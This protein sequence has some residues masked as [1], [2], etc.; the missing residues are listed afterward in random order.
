M[1]M[2]RR[3]F[4]KAVGVVGAGTVAVTHVPAVTGAATALLLKQK[5]EPLPPVQ[6]NDV[7][8]ASTW[9]ALVDRVNELSEAS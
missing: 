7:M 3:A 8:T 5:P 9:N 2:N 6:A 4:L 1:G